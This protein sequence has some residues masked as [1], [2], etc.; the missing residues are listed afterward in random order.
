M[1]NTLWTISDLFVQMT[2]LPMGIVTVLGLKPEFWMVTLIVTGFGAGVGVGVG[3]GVGLGVGVTS[4]VGVA[5]GARD[6]VAVGLTWTAGCEEDVFDDEPLRLPS[7]TKA[8]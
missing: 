5:V 6:V 8:P 4:G 2:V 7:T 3:R 1:L